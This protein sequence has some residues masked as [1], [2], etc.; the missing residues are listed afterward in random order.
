MRSTVR[1]VLSALA[2]VFVAIAWTTESSASTVPPPADPALPDE[3][4][5]RSFLQLW[6]DGSR[7]QEVVPLVEASTLAP[8]RVATATMHCA[9]VMGVAPSYVLVPV[10]SED[11]G[12]C[13]GKSWRTSLAVA[14]CVA[15]ANV[16]VGA[17]RAWRIVRAVRKGLGVKGLLGAA[18]GACGTAWLALLDLAECLGGQAAYGDTRLAEVKHHLRTLA[19]F[20]AELTAY[21]AD[22]GNPEGPVIPEE[23]H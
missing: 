5:G 20:D 19:E 9:E 14:G 15:S 23:L 10:A 18:M 8:S 22:H 12:P 1:T 21:L 2:T 11:G 6:H 13:R 7:L 3:L 4:V 17:F 16:A